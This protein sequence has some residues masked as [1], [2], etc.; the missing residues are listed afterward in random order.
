MSHHD[1]AHDAPTRSH[2]YTPRYDTSYTPRQHT[3]RRSKG[4]W[5]KVPLIV[6]TLL[7]G[8]AAAGTFWLMQAYADRIYPEVSLQG[9]YVG[10]KTRPDAQQAVEA[11]YASFLE[12]PVTLRYGDQ[13][14]QPSMAELGVAIDWDRSYNQAY[15]VGHSGNFTENA[16]HLLGMAP[17]ANVPLYMAVDGK[18]LDAYLREIANDIQV[19]PQEATISFDQGVVQ[20]TPS[21]NGR[22]VLL[23]ETAEAIVEALGQLQQQ[24]VEIQT[25]DVAPQVT[26][27]HVAEVRSEVEAIV[28]APL[29]LV[30]EDK[31]FTLGAETLWQLLSI[32]RTE[33]AGAVSL[34]AQIDPAKLDPF[35]R[36]ITADV[37]VPAVE[38]RVRWND[39][40]LEIFQEGV[41]GHGVDIDQAIE[42]ISS[43][44][45]TASRQV[46][47]PMGE[48]LPQVRP[49]TLDSLGITELVAEG[50]SQFTGSAPYRV[51]NIKAGV[52]LL[53][54]IMIA[55]GA[56]FSFN[57]T[58]GSLTE[59]KG[60]TQGYAIVGTRSQLEFGGGICQDS[61][62]LYRA[63]FYAGLP[64]TE[65]ASHSFRIEWYELGETIGMDA[66][67][68]TGTGPDL[69][70]VNDTGHWMLIQGAVD[71]ETST[72][73]FGLYGTQVEGRTVERSEPRISNARPAPVEPVYV[74]DPEVP[75]GTFKQTD[76]ARGGMDVVITRTVI[77]NGDVARTEDFV[78]NFQPWPNIYLKNPGTPPPAEPP[79]S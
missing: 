50:R 13:S 17:V 53:H 65:R 46:E 3:S 23:T 47:L 16:R 9:V 28:G 78:S 18:Q 42:V 59:D 67:I 5:W 74:D 43:A 79:S 54:G 63:A 19:Q 21:A 51:T 38:P 48:I 15:A 77:E 26:D 34:H 71:E 6:V 45:Q 31:R 75:V 64:I 22:M 62:T 37:G 69:R 72:V 14:W 36:R 56:E 8:A 10:G 60:F 40:A 12:T 73:T 27:Q 52:N 35:L 24:D 2:V 32:E 57:N 33:Q 39:G 70:F 7:V 44:V 1:S 41:P 4:L 68:F 49:E 11:A 66:A 29:E 76:K 20:T 55:P 30:A 58:V 61:T 25:Q